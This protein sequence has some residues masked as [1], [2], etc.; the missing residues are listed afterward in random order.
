[1][2]CLHVAAKMGES[3]E[4]V[5]LL[6]GKGV[7]INILDDSGVSETVLLI[8]QEELYPLFICFAD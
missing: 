3:L 2:T 8:Q 1:M 5:K 6:I 7:D 4:I